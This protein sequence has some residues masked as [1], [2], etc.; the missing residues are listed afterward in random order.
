V[1]L[2]LVKRISS[3]RLYIP[4]DLRSP[5]SRQSVGKSIQV[6][7]IIYIVRFNSI[8]DIILNTTIHLVVVVV[9][10]DYI[11]AVVDIATAE[12]LV[13]VDVVVV[14]V[15]IVGDG[16]VVVVIADVAAADVVEVVDVVAAVVD[17]TIVVIFVDSDVVFA[18]AVVVVVSC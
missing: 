10:V 1:L 18:I 13:D 4:K 17:V 16:V 3:V 14:T 9:V 15:V 6:K 2:N 7:Y 12:D 5:D 11:A 8:R